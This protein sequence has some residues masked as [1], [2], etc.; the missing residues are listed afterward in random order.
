MDQYGDDAAIAQQR[1]DDVRAVV[2][3]KQREHDEQK[4]AG[5][6][7]QPVVDIDR[8]QEVAVIPFVLQVAVGAALVH[9]DWSREE[10]ALAAARTPEP[11]S[12]FQAGFERRT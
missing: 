5:E 9:P 6:G 4:R 11:E 10:L 12:S 1:Q 3:Q 7:R 2:S 8:P